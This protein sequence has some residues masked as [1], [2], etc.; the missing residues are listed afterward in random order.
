MESSQPPFPFDQQGLVALF[1][2]PAAPVAALDVGDA[3]RR[4]IERFLAE[5]G[6]ATTSDPGAARAQARGV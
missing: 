3:A 5:A 6:R 2:L 4:E 1:A